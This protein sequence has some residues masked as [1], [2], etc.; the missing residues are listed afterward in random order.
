MMHLTNVR[1]EAI[2]L[3]EDVWR[4]A[5]EAAQE[6]GWQPAG[7]R[8]PATRVHVDEIVDKA[9]IWSRLYDPP[10]GQEVMRTDAVALARALEMAAAQN[11]FSTDP[12]PWTQLA[13]FA[14]RGPFLISP[15]P[16]WS[17]DLASLRTALQ[18]PAA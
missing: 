1:G 3:E 10:K 11:H 16:A 13:E 18:E 14:G 15:G 7:T 2:T 8:S 12:A 17:A 4:S 6:H 9:E 5:L